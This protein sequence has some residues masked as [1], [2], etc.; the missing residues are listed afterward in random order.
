LSSHGFAPTFNPSHDSVAAFGRNITMWKRLA[1]IWTVVKGDARLLWLALRHPQAPGWLKLGA[2]GIVLYLVSPVDL[3][4]DVVPFFGVV[5]DIV[6]VPLAIR[7]LYRRLPAA[8]RDEIEAGA[9]V[10]RTASPPRP[11]DVVDM[12]K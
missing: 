11:A 1:I 10:R 6:L 9:G 12:P 3:I 7:W 8:L 5:D 2:V 4:P